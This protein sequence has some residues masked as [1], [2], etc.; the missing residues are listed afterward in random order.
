MAKED[1]ENPKKS[2]IPKKDKETPKK[3]KIPKFPPSPI[4]RQEILRPVQIEGKVRQEKSQLQEEKLKAFELQRLCHT[5]LPENDKGWAKRRQERID[6]RE[7]QER[8]EKS[9][10]KSD[11]VLNCT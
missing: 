8:L 4:P 10:M 5:F 9:K 2:K 3:F 1:D 7:R 6:E 11:C